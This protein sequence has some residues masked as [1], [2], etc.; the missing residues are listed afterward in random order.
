MKPPVAKMI[1]HA[2]ETHGH[3]RIDPYA[4]LKN[5]TDPDVNAYLEAENRYTATE[6]A[7]TEALQQ[8]LY[9]EMVGRIQETDLSVPVRIEGYLYYSRTE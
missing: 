1:D 5:K 2:S 7:H 9:E 6:M 3:H 4:W 8:S